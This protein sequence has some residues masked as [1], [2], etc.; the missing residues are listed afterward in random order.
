VEAADRLEH[1]E[2]G[3]RRQVLGVVPVAHGH[4]QVPVDAVEV[5]EVQLLERIAV[6][7]LRALDERP[8]VRLRHSRRARRLR[9]SHRA[10]LAR[11]RPGAN[12]TPASYAANPTRLSRANRFT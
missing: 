7:G 11:P 3:L 5:D 10:D 9:L 1:L 2:E 6:A 8:D 12:L 4:V